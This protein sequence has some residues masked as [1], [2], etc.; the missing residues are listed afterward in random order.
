ML[1]HG[2]D[3]LGTCKKS[4]GPYKILSQ[5]LRYFNLLL[6]Y[7]T[8]SESWWQTV[9]SQLHSGL[10][11]IF[12]SLLF[13]INVALKW[14]VFYDI[15]CSSQHVQSSLVYCS[16]ELRL[17]PRHVLVQNLPHF[18]SVHSKFLR[19]IVQGKL[20]SKSIQADQAVLHANYSV[21]HLIQ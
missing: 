11:Q 17:N 9:A 16:S 19:I 5:S 20:K 14:D 4:S 2:R 10:Q 6:L 21:V 15:S 3:T 13:H 1:S 7:E 18:S 12:N 8:A